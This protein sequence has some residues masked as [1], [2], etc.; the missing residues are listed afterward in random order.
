MKRLLVILVLLLGV[1]LTACE[2]DPY[3]V[4]CDAYPTHPDCYVEDPLDDDPSCADGY[5]YNGESCVPIVIDDS[6]EDGYVHDGTSCVFDNDAIGDYLDIYYINDTHGALVQDGREIGI[7]YL[8]NLIKTRK[9]QSPEQ[10]LFLAGGDILQGTAISNHY[11]GRSTIE[12]LNESLLDAFTI[13]NHEFDWGLDVI[14]RYADGDNTNGEADFPFLAANIHQ[15]EDDAI[16]DGFEPYT[17]LE[18]GDRKI[19]IIGTIGFGLESSIAAS[20]VAGYYFSD[21]VDL[22]AQYATHLRTNLDVDVVI[23]MAHDSGNLNQA[24]SALTGDARVDVIFNGHSHREYAI[25]MNGIPVVQSGS[26][27]EYVGHVR[28]FF[29]VSGV[30]TYEA[31]N[32]SRYSEVLLQTA[33]VEASSLL[34]SFID[35]TDALFNTPIITSGEDYYSSQLSDWLAHLMRVATGSDI[36]FHNYGGT[37]TGI[38]Q[39][40]TITMGTLYEI[41]P[42]DNIIKTVELDG[43]ILNILMARGMAYDSAYTSFEPGTLYVVAT[44]DYVFDQPDNPFL[45]GTNPTNTGIL[46]RDLVEE[47]LTLQAQVFDTFRITNPIQIIPNASMQQPIWHQKEDA[48]LFFLVPLSQTSQPLR[49]GQPCD[50]I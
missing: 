20:R 45:G 48:F 49:F 28:L 3:Q 2:E 34:Q 10:V 7:D 17:I 36:A 43:S 39:G 32:L 6:C 24:V 46:L 14:Q 42:F 18:R 19:G 26:S 8:A 5:T 23:V 30:D 44:N 15:T 12:L 11:E 35:E 40:Q 29:D 41:W 37:R 47:E 21:P 13:G 4:D 1:T 33:D 31:V 25:D 22:V 27:L 16:P 9:T 38:D 50:I